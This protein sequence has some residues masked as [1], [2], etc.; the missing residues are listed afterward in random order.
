MFQTINTLQINVAIFYVTRRRIPELMS[1]HLILLFNL[2][3]SVCEFG[4]AVVEAQQIVA[5]EARVI[6]NEYKT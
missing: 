5:A 1:E 6:Y 3:H 2:A 4:F